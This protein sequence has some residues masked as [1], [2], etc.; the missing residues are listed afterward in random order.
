[1]RMARIALWATGPFLAACGLLAWS[2]VVKFARPRATRTAARAAGLPSSRLAVRTFATI[3]CAL[4]VLGVAF[5]HAA[6]ALVGV[7]YVALAYVALRLLRLAPAKP[8]GCLGSSNAP[9][10]RA[11]VALNLSAAAVAFAAA[12]AG[13]PLA[14]IPSP[15]LQAMTFLVLVAVAIRLAAL[16]ID[17]LPLLRGVSGE[18]SRP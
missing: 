16:T 12:F 6:A 18:G 3:E 9:A 2:G 15:P 4:A 8:C 11:H 10:S 5:G 7:M 13:S 1:M 17:A 14:R